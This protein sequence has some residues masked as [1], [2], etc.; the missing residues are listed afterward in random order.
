[1]NDE[2]G[3]IGEHAANEEK[4]EEDSDNNVVDSALTRSHT[5]CDVL[6]CR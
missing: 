6:Q 5:V 3:A 1:M 2:E 4:E